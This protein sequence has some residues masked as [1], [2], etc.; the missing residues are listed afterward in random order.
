VKND[1]FGAVMGVSALKDR[2]DG[3]ETQVATHHSAVG[4]VSELVKISESIQAKVEANTHPGMEAPSREMIETWV[5]AWL[6][7]HLARAMER[8]MGSAIERVMAAQSTLAFLRPAPGLPM[9]TD[10][11][12]FLSAPPAILAA[13]PA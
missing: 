6:E 9:G 12:D 11:R 8:A 13:T 1:L 3:L 5:Q 2:M 7:E 10:P 4:Q